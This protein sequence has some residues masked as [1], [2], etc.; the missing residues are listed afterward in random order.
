M[1]IKSF[2]PLFWAPQ[3]DQIILKA[4]K[5]NDLGAFIFNQNIKNLHKYTYLK[6]QNRDIFV[7]TF[8][9]GHTS[10]NKNR[11]LFLVDHL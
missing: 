8:Y 7:F 3:R 4:L 1:Q 2:V 5:S 11:I 9:S 6:R 10:Y